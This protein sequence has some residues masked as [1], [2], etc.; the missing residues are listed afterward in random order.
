MLLSILPV[1]NKSP[2]KMQSQRSKRHFSSKM[3][4][5][6]DQQAHFPA[7]SPVGLYSTAISVWN[8][9][10]NQEPSGPMHHVDTYD[11]VESTVSCDILCHFL[12]IHESWTYKAEIN[13]QHSEIKK[14][15]S[16]RGAMPSSTVS[17]ALFISCEEF[18]IQTL[19]CHFYYYY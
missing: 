1:I 6:F 19:S 7:G 13:V 16:C 5:I 18:W 3:K 8:G 2:L 4:A 17:P 15:Q 12:S 9:V 14:P 11:T 10:N